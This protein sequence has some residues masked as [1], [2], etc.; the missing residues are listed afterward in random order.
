MDQKAKERIAIAKDAL[1][2]LRA[3]ALRAGKGH[4]VDPTN[5][6]YI[7]SLSTGFLDKQLRDCNL[8]SCSVC[9][10]GALF[11]AKAVRFDKVKACINIYCEKM[12]R[13]V[14]LDHFEESQI[15]LIET[16]YE[17]QSFGWHFSIAE[18]HDGEARAFYNS[19]PD[20]TERM[21]KILLNII[22]NKGTFVPE[23]L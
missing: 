3:G 1:K 19:H 14:L 6:C 12:N 20:N 16:Y 22:K 21:K 11:L 15:E 18:F 7:D 10:R 2:W 4:Y 17:G 13:E 23:Q 8:G 9:M 5:P